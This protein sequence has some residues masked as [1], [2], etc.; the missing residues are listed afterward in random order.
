[1]KSLLNILG[2]I[3]AAPFRLL[4]N[5]CKGGL[6]PRLSTIKDEWDFNN[7]ITFIGAYLFK[8]TFTVTYYLLMLYCFYELY[9]WMSPNG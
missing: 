8:V 2:M 4:W 6:G 3:F 1:M 9:C 7:K 5:K